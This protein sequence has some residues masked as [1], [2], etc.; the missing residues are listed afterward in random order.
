MNKNRIEAFSD[1]IIAIIITI[2]V[3]E[4]KTPHEASWKAITNLLP[5]FVSYVLSYVFVGIYWGN[6]HHL[7][8]TLPK[9]NSKVIWANFI[10]LFFLSLIPFSTGWMGETH[11]EKIPVF[12]YALNLVLVAISYFLLQQVI[13]KSWLYETHLII[14]LKKQEKKGLLSLFIYLIALVFALFIPIVSAVGFL[15]VSI[16]WLIP[17]KNIEKAFNEE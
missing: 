12:I 15:I 7:L 6:H 1:G 5:V 16:L 2:M 10:L 17:D 13:M 9:V 4:M 3:L 11:F 14:A 8:H